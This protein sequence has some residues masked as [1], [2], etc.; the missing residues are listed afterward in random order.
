MIADGLKLDVYFG[1]SLTVGGR[2]AGD[3][4]MDCFEDHGVR[5]AALYRGIEGFGIG[6]RIRTERFADLSS[7]L[8]LIAEAIDTREAIEAVLAD[9]DAIVRQG[10]VTLEHSLLAV[11]D[12]V[13]GAR[14]PDGVGAGARLTVYCGRGERAG[15]RS[16]HRAVVDLMR[17]RGAGGATVLLGVD[18]MYH[19]RRRRTGLLR[20]NADVPT[21]VIAVGPP[22]VLQEVATALPEVL[23][24]P[25]ANLERIA[26]VK[27]GGERLEPLPVIADVEG[28]DPPVWVAVRIYTRQSAHV[29]GGALYTT[30]TRRL[31]DAG[32]AGVTTVRGEWGFSGDE[33][34]FGDRFGTL[35]SHVPTYTVF[36]ERPS[37][38]AL[39]WP[40]VDEITAE[41]GV[42]TAALVPA[43]RERARGVEHG[44]LAIPSREDVLRLARRTSDPGR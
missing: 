21:A 29:H 23:A 38:L 24:E 35:R 13:R 17:R 32:A 15:R 12:D 27:H 4:L 19:G 34:P 42:V 11:G 25:I 26:I 8:P 37:T 40:V 5:A 43:Y 20:H 7:D 9:V 3:V 2:L 36:V 22:R 16:S 14:I 28:E 1:E 33:V 41:H 44:R 39:I 18:G 10:L 31:R 6:A 30:L